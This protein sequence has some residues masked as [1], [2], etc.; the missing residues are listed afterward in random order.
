MSGQQSS[1]ERPRVRILSP[2]LTNLIAAGEVVE[3][4]ASVVKELVENSLDAGA[5]RI[6]VDLAAAGTVMIRVQDNGLGMDGEDAVLALQRH[7]TS[8]IQTVD[9]IYAVSSLG[10]RGE[11]LPSIAAVS[12]LELITRTA[13]AMLATKLVVEG[14]RILER[15]QVGAPPGTRVSVFNL[16]LNTPA[17]RQQLRKPTTELTRI[18]EVMQG[19]ALGHPQV[20]FTLVHEGRRLLNTAGDG[21]LLSTAAQVLGSEIATHLLPAKVLTDGTMTVEVLAGKPAIARASRQLQFFLINGRPV[22]SDILRDTVE[23]HYKDRGLLMVHR[24]PVVIVRLVLPPHELDVNIHPSKQEVRFSR[25]EAV[26]RLVGHALAEALDTFDLASR[27]QLRPQ[28]VSPPADP[29]HQPAITAPRP[30]AAMAAAG[31]AKGMLRDDQA[32]FPGPGSRTDERRSS[33]AYFSGLEVLGV[34]DQTYLIAAGVEGLVLI[35]QHAAH[36]RIVFERL[37]RKGREAP[38]TRQTLSVPIAI[39]LD[40]ASMQAWLAY[41]EQMAEHGFVAEQF[42]ERSLLLR[43]VPVLYRGT[44]GADM[45]R[46]LLDAFASSGGSPARLEADLAQRTSA[47]CKS[48][49]KA[50]DALSPVEIKTL[51]QELDHCENPYTCPHGRPTTLVITVSELER[52]FKRTG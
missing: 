38:A 47:A 44:A 33:P 17:R 51:L 26:S 14:G 16:F 19:L 34:V 1:R 35:D 24:Y 32:P 7:A 41:G 31:P 52:Y 45:F 20:A 10:F 50:H 6:H 22:R 12:R 2:E 29:L 11:A 23:R 39:E 42:G 49:V 48:A 30:N 21:D 4:P 43:E 40:P 15:R 5:S 13:D 8:K 9:D 28:Q 36:E 46:D 25:P 3:R 27:I 18:I 37:L